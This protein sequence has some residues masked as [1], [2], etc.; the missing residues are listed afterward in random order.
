MMKLKTIK[1]YQFC[2]RRPITAQTQIVVGL[3]P[4]IQE[5]LMLLYIRFIELIIILY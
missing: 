4:D 5:Y 1:I 2:R 3:R